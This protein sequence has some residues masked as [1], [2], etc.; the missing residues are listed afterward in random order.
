ML[1]TSAHLEDEGF[2]TDLTGAFDGPGL[3]RDMPGGAWAALGIPQVGELSETVI[4]IIDASGGGPA[5][6]EAEANVQAEIGLQ[7]QDDLLSW[8]GDAAIF[9]QGTDLQSVGGGFVVESSDPDKTD[10]AVDAIAA[11]VRG[12]DPETLSPSR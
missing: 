11:R 6:D 9:V 3:V 10:A 5:V 8:M 1:E 2:L 12:D 4:E 7:L